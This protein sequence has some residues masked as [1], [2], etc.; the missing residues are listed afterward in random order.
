M[1]CMHILQMFNI[2]YYLYIKNKHFLMDTIF[3]DNYH[4]I[5]FNKDF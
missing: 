1:I 3:Q 5:H 4:Y 2:N